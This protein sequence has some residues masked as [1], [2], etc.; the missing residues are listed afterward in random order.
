MRESWPFSV[1]L[2]IGGV[3]LSSCPIM[4]GDVLGDDD[5]SIS[6]LISD[7]E[8][9]SDDVSGINSLVFVESSD[10]ISFSVGILDT[11]SGLYG[12]DA[13]RGC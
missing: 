11:L 8:V 2:T 12:V 6:F 10:V 5:V 13:S 7:C 3:F 1:G 9:S 4:D